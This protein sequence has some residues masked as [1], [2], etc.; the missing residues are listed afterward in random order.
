MRRAVRVTLKRD[1]TQGAGDSGV[2]RGWGQ[3]GHSHDMD[4][5]E[6]RPPAP[7]RVS[8]SGSSG[9]SA[10]G[11][12]RRG[13]RGRSPARLRGD[14]RWLVLPPEVGKRPWRWP[15][16][17]QRVQRLARGPSLSS[18][19]CERAT[20]HRPPACRWDGKAPVTSWVGAS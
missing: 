15:K 7:S 20:K 19:P 10:S 12:D 9:G 16:L 13:G 5:G 6:R 18:R 14:P 11:Q 2:Q 4:P 3:T 17:L 1:I 8:R